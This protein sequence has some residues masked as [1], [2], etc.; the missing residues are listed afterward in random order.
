M[1][2][3]RVVTRFRPINTREENES[4][5]NGWI[6]EASCPIWV[7]REHLLQ[8]N[9]KENADRVGTDVECKQSEEYTNTFEFDNILVWVNQEMVFR[10]V[11]LPVVLDAL[12]GINGTIFTF[13]ASGSGKTFTMFG[14]EP[15][16]ENNAEL[17]GIVPRSCS[18]LFTSLAADPTVA[19]FQLEMEFF[20][21]YSDNEIRDLL[22]PGKKGDKPLRVRD[23]RNGIFVEGLRSEP[24]RNLTEALQ[25]IAIAHS[26]FTESSSPSNT[27]MKI[28][29]TITHTYGSRSRAT[30]TFCDLAG[31]DKVVKTSADAI[32]INQSRA[33]LGNVVAKLAQVGSGKKTLVPFR[34]SALTHAL[35]DSLAGNCKTTLIIAASPHKCNIVQ[36]VNSFRFGSRC[37]LIKTKAKVNRELT[38]GQMMKRVRDLEARKKALEIQLAA[39]GGGGRYDANGVPICFG[40]GFKIVW[41][42]NVSPNDGAMYKSFLNSLRRQIT[43]KIQQFVHDAEK[44]NFTVQLS[45][46]GKTRVAVVIF[47]PIIGDNDES[48]EDSIE[49]TKR[50]RDQICEAVE[51]A[52]KKVLKGHTSVEPFDSGNLVNPQE[53]TKKQMMK[54]MRDLEFKEKMQVMFFLFLFFLFCCTLSLLLFCIID[55]HKQDHDTN[56]TTRRH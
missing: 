52:P 17:L 41:K 48:E 14:P 22:H 29:L 11:G 9:E 16:T 54:M 32:R 15:S 5:A 21:I 39:G 46:P 23:G 40:T 12:Q 38:K 44:I 7:D 24:A 34:D 43:L 56:S 37:K 55:R 3:I 8:Y 1:P 20:E 51:R 4:K 6:G 26:H 13:G 28:F 33:P 30:L 50:L 25:M 47:S 42:R 45:R 35:K 10:E 27:I 53:F 49:T 19:S 2:A 18:H 36:T 31:S